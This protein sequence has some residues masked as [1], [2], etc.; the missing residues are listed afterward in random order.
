MPD[1]TVEFLAQQTVL[2]S[3]TRILLSQTGVV[4]LQRSDTR[5]Q[6]FDFLE[7]RGVGHATLTGKQT[8]RSNS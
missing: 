8:G 2:F 5:T 6:L 3:Q 7:Q 1:K 4:G